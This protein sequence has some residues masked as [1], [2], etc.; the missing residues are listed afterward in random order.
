[1]PGELRTHTLEYHGIRCAECKYGRWEFLG[2]SEDSRESGTNVCHQDIV[3]PDHGCPDAAM[4]I[5][6]YSVILCQDNHGGY[7]FILHCSI[8]S[9]PTD[10]SLFAACL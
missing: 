4:A 2:R 7:F 9:V 1:M 6:Q 5:R 3:E 8:R 10:E